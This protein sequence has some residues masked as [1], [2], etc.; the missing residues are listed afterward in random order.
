MPMLLGSK[1]KALRHA[2]G[3]T[4]TRLKKSQVGGDIKKEKLIV[5]CRRWCQD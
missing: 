4:T 5:V 1:V 3:R 2:T